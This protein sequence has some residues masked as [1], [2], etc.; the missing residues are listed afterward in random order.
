MSSTA[1]PVRSLAA[2]ALAGALSLTAACG[3]GEPEAAETPTTP[4]PSAP[5]SPPTPAAPSAEPEARTVEIT[6]ADGDVTPSGKKV[7]LETG[8]ELVLKISAEEAGE[9]HV[10][11]SPEQTIAFPTGDSEHRVTIDRPGLVEVEAH[12]PH[13]LVLQLE[14]R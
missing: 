4:S 1:R 6:F 8:E 10:H 9:L 7:E 13:K 2:V 3:S 14:V 12:H 11:S 5:Q